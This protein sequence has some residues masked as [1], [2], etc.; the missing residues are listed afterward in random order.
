MCGDTYKPYKPYGGHQFSISAEY[1]IPLLSFH[2]SLINV[3]VMPT[4]VPTA[5]PDTAMDMQDE[6]PLARLPSEVLACITHWL[7]TPEYSAVRETCKLI[8]R[9]TFDQWSNE[10]FSARQIMISTLS[11]DTLG[12]IA[13]HGELCLSVRELVISGDSIP[14]TCRQ[15]HS[16]PQQ[17]QALQTAYQDQLWLFST[18]LW[19]TQVAEAM[20][21]FPR[22]ATISIRNSNFPRQRHRDGSQAFW[23]SYGAETLVRETGMGLESGT[24]KNAVF[25]G[26]VLAIVQ[27]G[28]TAPN[29][30]D[31]R[32][33]VTDAGLYIPPETLFELEPFLDNLERFHIS[34]GCNKPVDHSYGIM[35]NLRK[36]ISRVPHLTSLG[37]NLSTKW[38]QPHSRHFWEWF[39]QS[40]ATPK[41]PAHDKP[42]LVLP[43][44]K[45]LEIGRGV[46]MPDVILEIIRKYRLRCLSLRETSLLDGTVLRGT[47]P[48]NLW[49]EF[50]RSLDKT[51]LRRLSVD[52][53]R[54][55]GYSSH[56]ADI[57]NGEYYLHCTSRIAFG[58]DYKPYIV[59]PSP[60]YST[61]DM[62]RRVA[63]SVHMVDVSDS[64]DEDSDD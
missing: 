46:F 48:D 30:V 13:R 64:S 63:D 29:F 18:G 60:G 14:E 59:L 24:N 23:H 27:S 38:Y 2:L 16:T 9:K 40:P 44:L 54:Q 57:L 58:Q 20:A 32:D 42:N 41:S 49:A 22:L 62:F 35:P 61:S 25:Q 37:V 19:I 6:S 50:F 28:V 51:H 10:F 53:C 1:S 21:R 36:L 47:D 56:G 12:D 33:E 11:L 7:T 55:D 31:Y 3:I 52:R 43:Y 4:A 15:A 5:S 34:G 45:T 8:E 39:S 17:E 26:T